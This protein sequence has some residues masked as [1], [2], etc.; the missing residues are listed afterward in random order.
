MYGLFTKLNDNAAKCNI[1]KRLVACK[2]GN[3]SNL[4]THLQ[5]RHSINLK[6]AC[7]TASANT[8]S[9]HP[10][11][12][13]ADEICQPKNV[14]VSTSSSRG[15]TGYRSKNKYVVINSGHS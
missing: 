15:N 2:G 1:C 14:T 9:V 11:S 7:L 6:A 13:N 3:T 8:S 5:I 10:H 12:S 4:V